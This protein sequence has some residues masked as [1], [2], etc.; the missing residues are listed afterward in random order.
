MEEEHDGG[1]LTHDNG[2]GKSK[3]TGEGKTGPNKNLDA[4]D[5]S[6]KEGSGGYH[7]RD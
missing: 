5:K 7:S 6:A 4:Y 3:N 2:V 1:K